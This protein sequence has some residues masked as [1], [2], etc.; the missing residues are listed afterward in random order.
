MIVDYATPGSEDELSGIMHRLLNS[1]GE[2]P[3]MT[4]TVGEMIF[5][6]WELDGYIGIIQMLSDILGVPLP[7][8]NKNINTFVLLLLLRTNDKPYHYNHL[9]YRRIHALDI[10]TE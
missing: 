8:V 1:I 7:P 10:I 4:R 9:S 3:F 2:G 6:G 5:E